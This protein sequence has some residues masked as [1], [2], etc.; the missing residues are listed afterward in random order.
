MEPDPPVNV[1]ALL[2]NG[3]DVPIDCVYAGEVDGIHMWKSV[4]VFPVGEIA[5]IT[6]GK[7]PAKTSVQIMEMNT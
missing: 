6:V 7:L 4:R 1:R 3:T 2:N 5:S